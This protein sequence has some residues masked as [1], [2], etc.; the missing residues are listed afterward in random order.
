MRCVTRGRKLAPPLHPVEVVLAQRAGL[1]RLPQD[2]GRRH[3][4]LHRQIDADAADGGHGVRRIA[5]AEQARLV[6]V[7]ETIDR[8]GQQLD[9]I[10]VLEVVDPVGEDG[11]DLRNAAPERRQSGAFDF[12]GCTLA[13]HEGALPVVAAIEHDD[14]APYFE[15][16][17]RLIGV[18]GFLRQAEPQHVHRR[19]EIVGLQSGTRAHSR[20][21]PI[22]SNREVGAHFK[23][24]VGCVGAHARDAAV[25]LDQVDRLRPHV[26]MER[27]IALAVLGEEV[28]EVPLRHQ[29]DEFAAGRQVG[30]IR[31]RI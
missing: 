3:R 20:V 18:V 14:D 30:E 12:F 1:E 13:N 9:L 29:R 16:A 31:E 7:W 21:P 2:V 26:Q 10:P 23:R 19:A 15:S 5:D 11:R 17:H 4:V 24:A 28:E 27:R 8:D 22:A 6:P 25:V